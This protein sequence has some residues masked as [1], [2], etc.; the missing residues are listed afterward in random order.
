MKVN[1]K[2]L[3][4]MIIGIIVTICIIFLS[5]EYPTSNIVEKRVP[6]YD[7]NGNQIGYYIEY[8]KQPTLLSA[9]M[10]SAL[11]LGLAFTFIGGFNFRDCD[12]RC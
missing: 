12:K 2:Y 3:S 7:M 6:V 10:F 5:V 1:L 9:I 8:E 4:L 11:F